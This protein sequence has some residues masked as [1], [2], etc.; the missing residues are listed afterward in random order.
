M[1][2]CFKIVIFMGKFSLNMKKILLIAYSYPP[3]EDAQSLRWYYISQEL[4]KLGFDIDVVTIKHPDTL[5]YKME[6]NIMIHRVYAGFFENIAY[7]VKNKIGVDKVENQE[8]RKSFSFSIMKKAYWMVRTFVGGILPGNISSEWYPHAKRYIKNN[9][10]ISSY[11]CMITSHEPWVDS[12]LGLHIKKNHPNLL[13]IADFGDPYVSIYTPKHKLFFENKIEKKIY[14]SLDIMILTNK[15]VLENLTVKYPFLKEKETLILEQGFVE[16]EYH[17]RKENSVFTILYTGTFYEDF[18]NPS[19]L[20][21]ALA[22]LGFEFRFIV[23]GRNEQFNTFFEPLK[24]KYQAL[25]FTAHQKVLK[26]QEEA[27]LLVHISNKQVEQ[28]PGKFYEYLGADKPMLVIYQDEK[29]QLLPL[30]KEIGIKTVCQ[31][32]LSAIKD[33][34]EGIYHDRTHNYDKERLMEFSWENR[35]LKLKDVILQE[36]DR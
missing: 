5:V 4:A 18:R 14:E 36:K 28:V 8:K 9:I 35:A 6:E 27:D 7:R 16:R 12:L 11:D 24:Q 2:I 23:A 1:K 15:K 29:D 31:N 3:L 10:D 30:C 20:A 33:M 22:S 32:E 26:L 19:E 17:D 21:K 34:I 25:G 13:W